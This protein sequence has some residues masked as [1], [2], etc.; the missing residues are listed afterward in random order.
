ML[1][2]GDVLIR[3]VAKVPAGLKRV[4]LEGGRIVLAHGEA[5]GHAHVVDGEALFL[6]ADLAELEG[7]FLQVEAETAGMVDAYRCR[8]EGD[9][10]C[11][12]PADATLTKI[13]AAGFTI[14]GREMVQGV[15]VRHDE[16]L[17]FVVTPGDFE[18]VRQREY[19]PEEIRTVAD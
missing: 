15:P 19:S 11:W 14:L 12:I 16:H 4:P 18:V 7:R 6:A 9:G 17:P 3:P 10:E 5:T 1:R 2:Q 13:E 8:R